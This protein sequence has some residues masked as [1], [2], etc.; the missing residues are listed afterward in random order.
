M[1]EEV[2][3]RF[4]GQVSYVERNPPSKPRFPPARFT[5]RLNAFPNNLPRSI[6]AIFLA[7]GLR[8]S[9]LTNLTPYV[10]SD[11]Q[12]H[13]LL[14][15]IG[16]V[17]DAMTSAVYI[18]MAKLLDIWGRAEGFLLMVGFSTLGVILMATS[19]NLATF[20][21]AQVSDEAPNLCLC[22]YASKMLTFLAEQ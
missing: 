2:A 1:D 15:V 20:C 18:P 22:G 7:N 19:H 21:A 3:R 4:A 11:F 8:L 17:S 16:V 14:T 10:T 6:W 9:I 13:S 5:W 12:S